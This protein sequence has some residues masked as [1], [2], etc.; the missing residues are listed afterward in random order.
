[1]AKVTIRDSER[2][3]T[4]PAEI[5]E[6]VDQYSLEYERWDIDKWHSDEAQQLEAETEEE[7]ILEV[8]SDEIER[9]KQRG[10]Y[11]TADVV[12]L[13]PDTPNLDELLAKFDKEHEH[14]EDEVRFVVDGRGIFTIHGEDD[15]VFDV[16]VH[17]GDLLVV[18]E[19]TWHWFDLCEDKQ[20]KCIRVFS[21]KDGWVAHYRDPQ[22]A[23]E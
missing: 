18:P 1:M 19:G 15:T 20:I 12:A 5:E 6:F 14:T 8:F 21:S 13:S 2:V 17:P 4:D 22:V 7:R 10:G 11:Q 9:L 23:A 3:L 16:E